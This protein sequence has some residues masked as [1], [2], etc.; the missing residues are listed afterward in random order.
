MGLANRVQMRALPPP[1]N[2]SD[3][4]SIVTVRLKDGRSYSEEISAF[5]GTPER[6]MGTTELRE[7]FLMLTSDEGKTRMQ[8][9]FLRLLNLENETNTRWIG[10]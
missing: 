3:M 2:T 5:L 8:E 4:S 10:A 7:K 6:P 1:G 9:T